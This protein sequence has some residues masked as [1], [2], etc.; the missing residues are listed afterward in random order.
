MS[1]VHITHI[2]TYLPERKISTAEVSE[3]IQFTHNPIS[4]SVLLRM[5][6]VK[7]RHVA[8]VDEQVS[9]MAVS[10]ALPI[11]EKVG[12][13]SIDLMI[14][15]SASSDLIEPATANIIQHKLGLDCA[16][17]D[18]K[19][20]CNSFITALDIAK[21]YISN[22]T[23][24]RVLIVNGEKLSDSIQF[25]HTDKESM[26]E[27]LAAFSF[28]DAGAAALVEACP[29]DK[30]ILFQKI[31]SRGKYWKLCTINGGGSMHPRDMSKLYFTG[32]TTELREAFM[33]EFR[34]ELV[35]SKEFID[36]VIPRIKWV[37]T[38]QVSVSSFDAIA[39]TIGIPV[40]KFVS[41]VEDVGNCAAASIPLSIRKALDTGQLQEGDEILIIG[42]GSGLAL[43]ITYMVW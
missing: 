1:N 27:H 42:L 15:A 20:A 13:E 11:V 32:F 18:V 40:W 31:Y 12:R 25:H 35:L 14:F 33:T 41:V 28:G 17:F 22:G 43:S 2:N 10:A 3:R 19:N 7:N 38:H 30:G 16:V 26:S 5:F 9:D 23:C 29:D 34:R 39:K 4:E 37:F 8:G 21:Q 24:Q 36:A 6:G